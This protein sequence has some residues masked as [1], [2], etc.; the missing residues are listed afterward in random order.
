MELFGQFRLPLFS[1]VRRAEHCQTLHLATIEELPGNQPGFN[2]FADAHVIRDEQPD[3]IEFEG[4]QQWHQLVRAGLDINP[5]KG[6]E[7]PGAGAKT[8]AHCISQQPAGAEITHLCWI[9]VIKGSRFDI[10]PFQGEIYS[11]DLM[12]CTS[13]GTQHQEIICGIGQ[14]HPFTTACIHQGSYSI[15]HMT[16]PY[17]FTFPNT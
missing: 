4:H 9:R 11:G 8:Q 6:A 14:D 15:T 17:A 13:Q 3:R 10:F 7:R 5:G 1:Q 12:I 2:R 16:S